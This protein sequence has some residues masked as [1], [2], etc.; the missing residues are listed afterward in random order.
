MTA[1]V[2]ANDFILTGK[3]LRK[4][5]GAFDA[6]KNFDLAVAEG[7]IHGLIGPN[8]AGKTTVF[9]LLTK[10]L[11]VT[12]GTITFR[13]RDITG[14]ASAEIARLGIV[15][16][17]QISATFPHMTVRDNLRVALQRRAGLSSQFWLPLSTLNR[18]DDRVHELVGWVGLSAYVDVRAGELSYGR[19][20]ALELATTLALEPDVMLLD[21]PMAGMAHEDIAEISALIG[22][23]SKG[24]TIVMIEHN[25]SVVSALCDCITVLQRGAVVASGNYAEISAN[26]L[27]R[28]AYLGEDDDDE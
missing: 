19:K 2:P 22:R 4:T 18:L 17:F 25:L 23:M 21:E 14:L 12:A 9:N 24:R 10:S 1:S 28:Q 6:V 27:V 26:P 15:R 11:G 5:F 8:G 3:G 16:S 20:R 7:S 13:G